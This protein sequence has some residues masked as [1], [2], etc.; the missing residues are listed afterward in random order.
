[1]NS[2][3]ETAGVV[4]TQARDT[5]TYLAR[6]AQEH[7]I[8]VAVTV[9]AMAW[10]MMRGRDRSDY[11]GINDTTWDDEDVVYGSDRRSLRDRVG[12]Y[13][14]SA[15]NY[16]SAAR[17]TV[18]E[19]AAGARETVGSYAVGAREVVGDYA[20]SAR[21]SARRASDRVR[22]AATTAYS[23]TGDWISDNPMAAGAIALALGAAIGM[24]IPRTQAEDRTMGEAR[25]RAW[26]RASEA[27]RNLKEN[28][29]E[30][31]ASAAENFT[32][33]SLF[34]TPAARKDPMGHV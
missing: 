21:T 22:G 15:R 20:S 6:Y 32:A 19:Y 34:G 11:D 1:M 9:G 7:P 10:W 16:A 28:V 33:D 14:S 27:A 5:G 25:D 24:S 3:G 26:Q 2:A 4:A 23:S 31:V 12:D 17:D 13:A 8:R 30:K 18:G 29:T